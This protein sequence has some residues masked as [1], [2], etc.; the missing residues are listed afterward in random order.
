MYKSLYRRVSKKV[1]LKKTVD[2]IIYSA[3]SVIIQS[4]DNE[5][6]IADYALCTLSTGVL[7]SD[8]RLKGKGKGILGARETR[9]VREKGGK[10]T[11]FPSLPPRASRPPVS[12]A[13][14]TPFP[15]PA[16]CLPRRLY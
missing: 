13:P 10:E 11:P 7:A 16:K 2:R 12:L 15:F 1:L 8:R 3:N 9:G 6:F 5:T 14:K 4:K